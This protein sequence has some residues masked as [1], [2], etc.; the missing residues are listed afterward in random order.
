M[1]RSV[2]CLTAVLVFGSCAPVKTITA[3]ELRSHLLSAL[4]LASETDLFIG[5][6]EEGRLLRQF[7]IGHADYLREEA[8]RQAQEMRESRSDSGD[9]KAHGLCAEQLELLIHELTLI[10]V[11][12]H[13]ETLPEA[14]QRVQAIREALRAAEASL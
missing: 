11:P 3:D 6:I 8:R 10:R 13:D 14:C 7:R 1:K 12:D 2:L 4:S 9:T 5:Q